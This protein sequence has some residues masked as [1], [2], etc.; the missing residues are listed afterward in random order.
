[1]H[2]LRW[3]ALFLIVMLAACS[4]APKWSGI[5]LTGASFGKEFALADPDGKIRTLAEFKGRYVMLFFGFTQCPDI[6][7]TA[8]ARAAMVKKLLGADGDKLQVIFITVDPDRDTPQLLREYTAAFDPGFLGLRGDASATKK[9]AD[10][11]RVFYQK[12]ETGKSYTMDHT[13]LSYLFDAS[14]RLRLAATHTLS[15]EQ[16]AA[17]LRRLM[18]N[19]S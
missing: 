10:E 12:N 16:I 13:S 17:D 1:M 14:G 11:F 2:R 4:E 6:C 3:F 18:A 7:P 5:N 8:L 19:P 15:A 9:V